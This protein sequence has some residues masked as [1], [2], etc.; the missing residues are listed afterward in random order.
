MGPICRGG[1]LV[2]IGASRPEQVIES[3]ASLD[4]VLSSEQ[5]ARL[6]GVGAPP[7]LNPS[8]I[9]QMPRQQIFGR[10]HNRPWKGH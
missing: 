7:T 10:S 2:L 8:F 9:F 1:T 6:D 3:A 4:V 5:Q